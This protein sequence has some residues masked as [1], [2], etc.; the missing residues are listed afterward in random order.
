MSNIIYPLL[1]LQ[2]K[3]GVVVIFEVEDSFNI[4]ELEGYVINFFN[5]I[6]VIK[7]NNLL[8]PIETIDRLLMENKALKKEIYLAFKK[9]SEVTAT[10][11]ISITADENFVMDCKAALYAQYLVKAKEN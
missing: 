4:D 8:I 2:D 10:V 5:G 6:P 7:M 3:N 1:Y 9:K 11:D